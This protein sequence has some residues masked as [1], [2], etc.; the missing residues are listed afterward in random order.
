LLTNRR[1]PAAAYVT[2]IW[3]CGPILAIAYIA[4]V[5]CS[6]ISGVN[7]SFIQFLTIVFHGAYGTGAGL[8]I[9]VLV[10]IPAFLK[11]MVKSSHGISQ[12]LI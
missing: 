7:A 1:L 10:I 3:I 4:I 11:R 6:N 8:K 9:P 12:Y 2:V 5:V